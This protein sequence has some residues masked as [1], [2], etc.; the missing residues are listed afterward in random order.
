MK[1]SKIS[2]KT[3][4]MEPSGC[5]WTVGVKPSH[6][7]ASSLVEKETARSPNR[8]LLIHS[9]RPFIFVSYMLPRAYE[10]FKHFLL[11]NIHFI[12]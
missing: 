5:I 3:F 11:P 12:P 7:L 8:Q 10:S 2:E 9:T 6:M 1:S 4:S